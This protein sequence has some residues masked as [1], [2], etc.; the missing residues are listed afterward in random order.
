MT[1]LYGKLYQRNLISLS[2]YITC[3]VDKNDCIK[4]VHLDFCKVFDLVLNNTLI[5]H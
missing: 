1:W 4:L 3:L 2:D 5:K